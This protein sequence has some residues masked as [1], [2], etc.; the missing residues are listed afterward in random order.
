MICESKFVHQQWCLRLQWKQTEEAT[1][2]EWKQDKAT[3]LLT[4]EKRI[5]EG[6]LFAVGT[7][8]ALDQ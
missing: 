2:T 1:E 6:H 5:S 4:R 8:S 7:A 3:G